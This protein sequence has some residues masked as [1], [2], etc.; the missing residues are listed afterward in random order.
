M[1]LRADF[2][3]VEN[4]QFEQYPPFEQALTVLYGKQDQEASDQSV[5]AWQE[6]S[7]QPRDIHAFDGDHFFIFEYMQDVVAIINRAIEKSTK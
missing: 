6:F 4:Y 3:A 5:A 1:G 2:K 7:T